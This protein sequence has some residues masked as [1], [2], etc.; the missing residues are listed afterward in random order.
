METMLAWL[1]R[2][3]RAGT[4]TEEKTALP[5]S[6][7]GSLEF[8]EALVKMVSL[9]EGFGDMLARGTIG[10]ANALGNEANAL[11]TDYII[12]STG[13]AFDSDPRMD[14]ITGLLYV[15]QPREHAAVSPISGTVGKWR[16][17]VK[18]VEGAYLSADVLQAISQRLFGDVSVV[19]FSADEGKALAVKRIQDR[20]SA[21][22]SLILCGFAWP[23]IDVACSDD[24]VGDPTLESQVFSAV[25][26]NE[27]DEEGLNEMGEVIF[28]LR[29]AIFAREGRKGRES[30]VLPEV[31]FSKPYGDRVNPEDP[32]LMPGKGGEAISK[33]GAIVDR[34]IFEKLKDEYYQLRRW[35]VAS[36]IQTKSKL[37]ELGLHDIVKNLEQRG[38]AV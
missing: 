1:I 31:F 24:H 23:I 12:H 25:T 5:L 15:M 38:L 4:L 16:E 20:W 35:D 14:I 18:V 11:I 2:C 33:K 10:A 29:R 13:Q 3:F 28:N 21:G 37:K 34:E 27:V 6:K 32:C 17:W 8:I 19:D 22:E 30:E 9:R 26:G 7:F 36:G